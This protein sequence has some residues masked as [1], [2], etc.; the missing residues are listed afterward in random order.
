[1]TTLGYGILW[2]DHH[3]MHAI[4]S[5]IRTLGGRGG[6]GRMGRGRLGD[7]PVEG[8]SIPTWQALENLQQLA[9]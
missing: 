2:L 9:S 6:D 5:V 3:S 4:C 1:M 7:A 8:Q